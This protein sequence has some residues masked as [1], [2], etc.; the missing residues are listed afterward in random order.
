MGALPNV[1]KEQV[2]RLK[3]QGLGGRRIAE[4]LGLS[5]GQV[6]YYLESDRPS[7]AVAQIRSQVW[8]LETT[9]LR[10]DM[11]TLLV[12]AFLDLGTGVMSVRS[13]NDFKGTQRERERQLALW[14]RDQVVESDILIGHNSLA[15]DKNFLNGVLARLGEDPLPPRQHVDTYQ[16]ARNGF[17]GYLQSYSMA[18]L[19]DFFGLAEQKDKPSKHDWRSA[20]IL[21]DDALLRITQR[22][23]AD[24]HV[25]ALLWEKMKPFWHKW[26]GK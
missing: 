10:S 23:V 6:R 18:N 5:Y 9:H 25:T 19:A 15:F 17:K 16:I 1:T 14:V 12:G 13:I 2:D 21:D 8:D 4:E 22:C 20:N 24:V 11:G 26:R 7:S 3:A